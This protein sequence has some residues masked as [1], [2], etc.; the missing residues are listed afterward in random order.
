FFDNSIACTFIDPYPQLLQDLL[1]D[2]DRQ[3]VAVL[4]QKVQD[5][6][7][8][9]FRKL[10]ASDVL[11]VDSSHVSKTGSDVNYI[12]FKILPLLQPGVRVHFHDIVY[13][14]EYPQDWVYEGR[15]WNEAYLLRAF[16]QYNRAF[17]IEFFNSFLIEKHPDIFE[18]ALPLCLKRPGSNFW[19]K[20]TL[21]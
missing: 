18:S 13:P 3:R 9:V 7:I 14:F 21:S 20:K 11:F 2:S 19:L 16:M 6:D 17:E 10:E 5:A 15:S 12:L 8:E 1:K 4:G